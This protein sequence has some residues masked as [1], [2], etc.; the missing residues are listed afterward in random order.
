MKPTIRSWTSLGLVRFVCLMEI[1]CNRFIFYT[2]KLLSP[3]AIILVFITVFS[4]E[5]LILKWRCFLWRFNLFKHL[6][7][8]EKHWCFIDLF[9][10]YKRPSYYLIVCIR[11]IL[12]MWMR[13]SNYNKLFLNCD[14]FIVYYNNLI[15]S[16]ITIER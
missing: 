15:R 6:I 7:S 16:V 9:F 4:S 1:V 5:V 13:L 11:E 12:Y 10:F 14:N 3:F 8:S 2:Y